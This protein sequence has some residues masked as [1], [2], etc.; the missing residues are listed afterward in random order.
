M[1]FY[2][3]LEDVDIYLTDYPGIINLAKGMSRIEQLEEIFNQHASNGTSLKLLFDTRNTVWESRET[4]DA[5]AKIARQ[6]FD[7]GA[8]NVRRFTAVLNNQY[9][10]PTF[11]NEHW[12]TNK[13][14]ALSWLLQQSAS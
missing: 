3:Y 2:Q 14:E 1:G 6:K 5:L 4:H 8:K 13:D 9:I 12:F 7:S 11:E 10:G